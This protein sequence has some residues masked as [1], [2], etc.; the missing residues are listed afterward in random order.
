MDIG[1]GG[2]GT[3]GRRRRLGCGEKGPGVH[4]A[5][6]DDVGKGGMGGRSSVRRVRRAAA[7]SRPSEERAGG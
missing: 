7:T 1:R 5:S 2:G 6:L 3:P 4:T